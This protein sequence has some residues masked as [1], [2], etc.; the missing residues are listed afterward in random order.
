MEQS[1]KPV[2]KTPKWIKKKCDY[3]GSSTH[4][5]IAKHMG[6]PA[7]TVEKNHVKAVCRSNIGRRGTVHE[8]GQEAT[9]DNIDMMNINLIIYECK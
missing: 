9:V 5:D 4:I 8:I 3:C 6:R 2:S 7:E 1:S